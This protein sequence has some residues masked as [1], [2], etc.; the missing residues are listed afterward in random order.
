MRLER[1]G[2]LKTFNKPIGSR[3]HDV[4]AYSSASTNCDTECPLPVALTPVLRS[5][6]HPNQWAP[7]ISLWG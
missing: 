7:G 4:S 3:P 5:A 6:E 2:K 1:L